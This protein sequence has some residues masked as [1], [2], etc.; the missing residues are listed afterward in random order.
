M[1]PKLLGLL[2]SL[3][4]LPA[5]QTKPLYSETKTLQGS[6]SYQDSLVFETEIQD[7]NQLYDLYLQLEHS[8]TYPFANLYCALNVHFPQGPARQELISLELAD[9]TGLWL[10]SCSKGNCLRSMMFLENAKFQQLGKYRLVFKQETRQDSL[11]E[12]R[13]LSLSIYNSPDKTK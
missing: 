10:G 2:L 12:I 7:T 1:Y 11:P 4:L 13:S 8:E 6:W 9:E 3:S 5:C